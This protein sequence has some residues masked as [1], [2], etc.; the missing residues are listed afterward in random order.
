MCVLSFWFNTLLIWFIRSTYIYIYIYIY[1]YKLVYS[2]WYS[3]SQ[4]K[5]S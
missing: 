2:I 1:I 4:L 5:D 3:Y